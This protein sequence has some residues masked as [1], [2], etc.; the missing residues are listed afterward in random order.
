MNLTNT[1]PSDF[2]PKRP[3][4]TYADKEGMPYAF[5]DDEVNEFI[6]YWTLQGTRRSLRG[7][8]TTFLNRIRYKWADKKKREKSTQGTNASHFR[9]DYQV[10][11][12]VSSESTITLE[13][14]LKTLRRV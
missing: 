12:V 9:E 8:D 14:R 10:E 11:K 2:L 3:M 7:W 5:I 1:V 13:Q 4:Y 6:A